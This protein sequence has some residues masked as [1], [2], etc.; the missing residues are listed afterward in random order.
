MSKRSD[1]LIVGQT[2]PPYHGQAVVTAMLFDHDWED[3]R[4]E[5]LRMA[6][7]DSIGA[8]GK[9]SL[10]KV[11]HLFGLVLKTWKLVLCRRPAVLYYLPASANRAPVLRDFIYLTLVRWCFRKKVFHYHAGGLPEYLQSAGWFGKLAARVYRG[12]DVS[13]EICDTDNSPGEFFKAKKT[14]IVP[15][16]LNVMEVARRRQTEIPRALFIGSLSEGKGILELIKT[17]SSLKGRGCEIEFQVVGGWGSPEFEAEAQ[18]L[19]RDAGVAEMITFSGVLAGDD[20]WQA[21]A[22]ADLFFFPSHYGAENFP[23]V[24][25]EALAY[26]LPIVSTRWRGIPQLVGDGGAAILCDTKSPGQFA[27]AIEELCENVDGERERMGAAALEHYRKRF[28]EE[29]FVE[30]MAECFREVRGA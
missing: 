5:R 18:A 26:R 15:N 19:L 6:Y 10:G 11:F 8:V 4:V 28:T 27:D 13:V 24:L 9:V 23:L 7:S 14:V 2:P 21:Y 17:A 25:I 30:A 29:R 22:D 1:I 3:L 16:G 12:A 20:K